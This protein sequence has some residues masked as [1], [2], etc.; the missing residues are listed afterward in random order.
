RRRPSQA[1]KAPSRMYVANI[2]FPKPRAA[3]A[4]TGT[5]NRATDRRSGPAVLLE[6][7][8]G[9]DLFESG[10]DLLG[11]FLA[12]AFLDRLGSALDQIL[13]F[14]E[15]KAGHGAHFLNHFD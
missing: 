4:R 10:L 12:N 14:L 8:L 7:D 11:L 6:F 13:G 15:A 5:A 9:A 3:P 2:K 1:L